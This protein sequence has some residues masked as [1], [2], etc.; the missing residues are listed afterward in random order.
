MGMHPGYL[1]SHAGLQSASDMSGVMTT[2]FSDTPDAEQAAV[3]MANANQLKALLR[4]YGAGDQRQF[5]SIAEQLAAHESRRGHKHLAEELSRLIGDMKSRAQTI[6]EPRPITPIA[7]PKGELS[8]LLSVT[9]PKQRLVDLILPPALHHRL[10]RII[11]EQRHASRIRSHG[12]HPRRKILFVGP[13]GTGKTLSAAVLAGELSLPLFEVRLE[14]LITKFMGETAA[15]LRLIFDG[16][17]QSRGVYLFDEFD[18]IG[19]HR[20]L[21][22][23][24]GEI[25]RILNSFL[26]F[27]DSDSSQSLILAATNHPEILDYALFRRFDDV[28]RYELPSAAQI[29]Q[30]LQSKLASVPK[31]W[32]SWRRLTEE[33]RAMSYAE[34]VRACEDAVKHMVIS[35]RDA[36]PEEY[37]VQ[38]LNERKAIANA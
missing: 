1:Q 15:K 32:K 30:T 23:D 6:G 28:I 5:L 13:P 19:S 26:Q 14:R 20:G 25:R 2:K 29:T 33:A 37:V 10:E 12:L 3:F 27:I 38:A 11:K 18:S 34:I 35:N 21:S 9:Y 16:I 8:G 36:L 22:N 24:V 17:A 31:V 7:Q 4:A